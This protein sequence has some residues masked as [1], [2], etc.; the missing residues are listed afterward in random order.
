MGLRSRSERMNDSDISPSSDATV[1]AERAVVDASASHVEI[2]PAQQPRDG[3][4]DEHGDG[5]TIEVAA[6]AGRTRA[7][8]A[9]REEGAEHA[10]GDLREV[11][12]ARQGGHE[13]EAARRR[14]RTGR[15][16]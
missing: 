8:E 4:A 6:Q 12:H 5:T 1:T 13:C 2:D 14:R 15:R 10:D 16:S 3:R 9:E 7:D 11:D